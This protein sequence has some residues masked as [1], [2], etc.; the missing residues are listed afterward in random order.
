MVEEQSHKLHRRA[1]MLAMIELMFELHYMVM[2]LCLC[3]A[4]PPI[5][6]VVLRSDKCVRVFILHFADIL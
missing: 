5:M 1:R 2:Q 6:R 3:V 4:D